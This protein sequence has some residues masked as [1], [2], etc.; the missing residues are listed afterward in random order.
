MTMIFREAGKEDA[1]AYSDLAI[2]LWSDADVKE[3]EEEFIDLAED[4]D[5]V[6]FL[7]IEDSTHVGFAHCQVRTD[8]VEGAD[9]SPVGYIEGIYVLEDYRNMGIARRLLRSCEDWARSK[10]ILEMAS[11]CEI[12][13]EESIDFHKKVGFSEANRGVCFIKNIEGH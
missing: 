3:L 7:A 11:D 6:V 10:G 1:A 5:S 13:N 2:R 8:Y 12:T 9:S 4:P